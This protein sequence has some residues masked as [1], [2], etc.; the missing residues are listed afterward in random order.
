MKELYT[1]TIKI[2]PNK[3]LEM[4]L[5]GWKTPKQ[6]S[7]EKAE[8]NE[9]ESLKM[10]QNIKLRGTRMD[11]DFIN[12]IYRTLE[13]MIVD[14]SGWSNSSIMLN[15]ENIKE[16]LMECR[17]KAGAYKIM[18]TYIEDIFPNTAPSKHKTKGH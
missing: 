8:Q 10:P 13:S 1:E 18:D 15:L 12:V 14:K 16:Q 2:V 9:R 17:S 3:H 6:V 4:A 7:F 11:H 5:S